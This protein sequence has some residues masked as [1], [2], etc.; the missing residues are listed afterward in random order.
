MSD[1]W[2]TF[3]KGG[4]VAGGAWIGRGGQLPNIPLRT[5]DSQRG[6]AEG[7]ASWHD[8]DRARP[9]PVDADWTRDSTQRALPIRRS[10]STLPAPLIIPVAADIAESK[11][12]SHS[13][14]GDEHASSRVVPAGLVTTA[15]RSVS[16]AAAPILLTQAA[17][18]ADAW[19]L[20]ECLRIL[21][22]PCPRI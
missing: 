10:H 15:S 3:G 12:D 19:H 5:V 21:R 22:R 11:G 4:F 8:L 18:V 13:L 16:A 14:F 9:E 1:G 17:G 2:A 6:G 7:V 20:D